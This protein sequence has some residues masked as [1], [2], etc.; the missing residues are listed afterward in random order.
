LPVANQSRFCH[1]FVDLSDSRKPHVIFTSP[2][3]PCPFL[4]FTKQPRKPAGS[5]WHV[6]QLLLPPCQFLAVLHGPAEAP[7]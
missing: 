5:T 3:F 7:R 6:L 1:G 4:A 2:P